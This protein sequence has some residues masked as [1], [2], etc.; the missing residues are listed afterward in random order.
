VRRYLIERLTPVQAAAILAV[1]G[2]AKG[3]ANTTADS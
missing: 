2:N 3:A 1:G